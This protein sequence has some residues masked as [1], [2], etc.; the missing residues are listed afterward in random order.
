MIRMRI[1]PVVLLPVLAA[2][3]I[4]TLF[5]V[6]QIGEL[7]SHAIQRHGWEACRSHAWLCEY[8]ARER[9]ER[10]WDCGKRMLFVDLIE[11]GR[12]AIVVTTPA[13]AVITAYECSNSQYILKSLSGCTNPY[14]ELP[15]GIR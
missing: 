8:D 15:D 2:I 11:A 10:M 14:R 12:W 1:S 5:A 9:A 7:S 13:G 4:I 6:A 3:L